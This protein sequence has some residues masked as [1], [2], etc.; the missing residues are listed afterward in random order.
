MDGDSCSQGWGFQ[1]PAPYTRWTFFHI[2]VVKIAM[3][4]SEDEN[5]RKEAG[6]AHFL[7]NEKKMLNNTTLPLKP[8]AKYLDKT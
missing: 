5:K 6:M 2:F 4:L 7:K 1:I 8:I 3:S